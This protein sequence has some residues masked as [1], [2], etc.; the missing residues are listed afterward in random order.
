MS[1]VKDKITIVEVLPGVFRVKF[2]NSPTY[3]TRSMTIG[4][5]I[6]WLC[7]WFLPDGTAGKKLTEECGASTAPWL[8]EE[9]E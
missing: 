7:N 5:L 6:E 3:I 8:T 1:K 9:F 2:S 4:Q